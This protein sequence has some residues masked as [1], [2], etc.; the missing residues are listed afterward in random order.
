MKPRSYTSTGIILS[1]R[2]YGEADKIITIYSKD[3]GKITLMAHGVRRPKSRK[4]GHL[5]IFNYIKFQGNVSNG[6]DTLVEAV[7]IEDFAGIRKSLKKISLAYYFCE[8][9]SKITNDKERNYTIFNLLIISLKNLKVKNLYK[10]QRL[11]FIHNLLVIT[12]YHPDGEK[13][14]N[15]DLVL[16]SVI[17]RGLNSQRVGK[18]L[19]MQ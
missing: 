5:E 2:N 7:V 1:K 15:H 17:E 4:R 8:V 11:A 12:G 19:L 10:Q 3:F 14:V 18:R 13:L 9:I 16:N 6:L